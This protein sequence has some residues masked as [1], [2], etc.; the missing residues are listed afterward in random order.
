MMTQKW[1]VKLNSQTFARIAF[2]LYFS[3]YF[4]QTVLSKLVGDHYSG[5]VTIVLIYGVAALACILNPKR[6]LKAD[7]L[8]LYFAILVFW[9]VSAILH[10]E[11][12]PFY[13]R[14]DYGVVDHV[15]NPLRG[16][17]AYFFIR[18]ISDEEDALRLLKIAGYLSVLYFLYT[19][20]VSSVRGYWYGVG[21]GIRNA[22][23]K[24][25]YS[26]AFGYRVLPVAL[27][28]LYC[29]LKEK[30]L[31][32]LVVSVVCI[33]LILV[34]GSRG[35][36]LF[37]GVFVVLYILTNLA[38]SGRKW[39]AIALIA[40]GSIGL[41]LV[42]EPLIMMLTDLLAKAGLSSRFLTKLIEGTIS[43]DSGR[44]VIWN[45][46]VKMIRAK[47]FGYGFMGSRHVI[48]RLI[49]AGYPHSIV[50]EMLIDFGV[51]FGGLILAVI[52]IGSLRILF[53]KRERRWKGVYLIYFSAACGLLISLTFWSEATFWMCLGIAANRAAAIRES[54]LE[55]KAAKREMLWEGQSWSRNP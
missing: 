20:H 15:L 26:V 7:F 50:L 25:R 40:A 43:T 1:V 3:R 11:Y 33:F 14:P 48:T 23:I 36:I 28:F 22:N 12:L 21:M 27:L 38:S 4:V 47:P 39:I 44:S 53:H 29:A 16:L 32:D 41:Y 8:L 2:V 49:Y 19:Y 54:R 52:L 24:M 34:A 31:S 42:Y 5:L 17:Y 37:V 18:M 51:V 9:M 6:Y 55:R 30:R 13:N 45:A 46:A 35:P 10:P